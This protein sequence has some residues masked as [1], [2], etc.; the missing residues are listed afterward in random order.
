MTG[1]CGPRCEALPRTGP[2]EASPVISVAA[3]SQWPAWRRRSSPPSWPGAGPAFSPCP[4][5]QPCTPSRGPPKGCVPPGP[6]RLPS[7]LR[8]RGRMTCL[9][10]RLRSS[11]SF[12]SF[13]SSCSLPVRLRQLLCPR[14]LVTRR[15][16]PPSPSSPPIGWLCWM[17][18]VFGR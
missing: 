5:A 14:P 1:N 17:V 6:S 3:A 18:V 15:L 2:G 8:R 11:S 9:R 12:S 4:P 7:A 16:S 10:R 13:S